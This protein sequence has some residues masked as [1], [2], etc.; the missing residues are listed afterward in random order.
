[1]A[2]LIH[3]YSVIVSWKSGNISGKIMENPWNL[4]LEFDWKPCVR[5]LC[6][7]ENLENYKSIFQIWKNRGIIFHSRQSGK[8]GEWRIM[9]LNS[10]TSWV[11]PI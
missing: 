6:I 2:F 9:E 10:G 5:V 7:M 1:M 8:N 4:I 11:A 3:I